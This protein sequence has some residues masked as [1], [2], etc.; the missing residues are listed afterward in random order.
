MPY[1]IVVWK[2]CKVNYFEIE[3]VTVRVCRYNKKHALLIL[4]KI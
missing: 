4:G 1:S 3:H 2:I